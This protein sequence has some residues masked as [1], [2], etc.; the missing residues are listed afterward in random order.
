HV[1]Y[2]VANTGNVRADARASVSVAELFGAHHRDGG[3]AAGELLPGGTRPADGRVHGVWGLG[4]V[5]AKILLSPADPAG[6][7]D[8][9]VWV[10]P[11]PQ[12]FAV[13]LLVALVLVLRARR[14]RFA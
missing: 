13:A 14:R 9:T 1:T 3:A 6:P 4:P 8:V 2:T 10:V 5:H 11:W 7:A 12:L